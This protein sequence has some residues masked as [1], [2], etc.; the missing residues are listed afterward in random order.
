M[1]DRQMDNI[2]ECR[3]AF[4]TENSDKSKWKNKLGSGSRYRRDLRPED[5]FGS[6]D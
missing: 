3:V 1:A 2:C 4:A 6:S 5:M